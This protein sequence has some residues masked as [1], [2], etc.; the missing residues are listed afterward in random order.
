MP[1]ILNIW[2][3]LTRNLFIFLSFCCFLTVFPISLI[4][5][6]FLSPFLL[7]YTV[8]FRNLLVF[9]ASLTSFDGRRSIF[10]GDLV[11]I[12]LTLCFSG[13]SSLAAAMTLIQAVLRISFP[14]SSLIIILFQLRSGRCRSR[15]RP[16]VVSHLN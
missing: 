16:E 11:T 12:T 6:T 14:R 2:I 7:N 3:L 15:D 10:F 13:S 5:L 4:S 9:S 1:S 8:F